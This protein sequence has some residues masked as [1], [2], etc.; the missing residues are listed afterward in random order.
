VTRQLQHHNNAM[1]AILFG[2]K[3]K[4]KKKKKR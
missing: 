2:I 3:K 1:G 4:K